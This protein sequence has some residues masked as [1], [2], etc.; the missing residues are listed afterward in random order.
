MKQKPTTV[1]PSKSENICLAKYVMKTMKKHACMLSH[2]R[3]YVTPWTVAHQ[4]LLSMRFSRQKYWSG[5]PFLPAGDLSH[6]GAE[7]MSL[8][9][10]H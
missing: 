6:P 2:V 3:L 9:Y 5:L 1:S 4:A 10:P 8:V 7:P